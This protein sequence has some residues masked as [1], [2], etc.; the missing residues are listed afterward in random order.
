MCTIADFVLGLTDEGTIGR[1]RAGPYYVFIQFTHESLGSRE[2]F[3]TKSWSQR[4]DRLG[5]ISVS[6]QN[7]ML[8]PAT[9]DCLLGRT[10]PFIASLSLSPEFYYRAFLLIN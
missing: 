1:S 2:Y 9:S 4:Q 10:E 3:T 8:L 5:I 6:K 7:A